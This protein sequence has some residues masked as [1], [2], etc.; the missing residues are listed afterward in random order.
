MT[1]HRPSECC[2]GAALSQE[3]YA[4]CDLQSCDAE[5]FPA[6]GNST[7]P[8]STPLPLAGGAGVRARQVALRPPA[9]AARP[10]SAFGTFSRKR[11]KERQ[12]AQGGP[13]VIVCRTLSRLRERG[14]GEGASGRVAASRACGAALIRLGTFSRERENGAARNPSREKKSSTEPLSRLRE[15]GRG[16]GASGRVAASRACG[17]AL[18]RL[19]HLLPR[20]GE[21]NSTEPLAGEGNSTEPLAGEGNSTEPFAGEG[22]ARNPSREK[23]QHGTPLPLAGEGQG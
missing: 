1:D 4:V 7:E 17:A 18:I 20:A 11:E 12:P 13:S 8:L 3:H 19:R 22:A 23:E 5:V 21:G 15:R 16:E 10:S 14:R 2:G 9:P 6:S